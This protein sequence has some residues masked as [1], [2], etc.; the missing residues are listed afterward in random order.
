[1]F[2][3]LLVLAASMG[4]R[5]IG[6]GAGLFAG[7]LVVGASIGVIMVLLPGIIKRDFGARAGTMTGVYT[8]ALCL[9]AALAA[10]L[11]VPLEQL[12]GNSW[13][14]ALAIWLVPALVAAVSWWPHMRHV[15]GQKT[16]RRYRVQGL[17]SSA[18]AWQVTAYLGLQSTLAY[19][20]FGWLPTIL[21]DRGMAPLAAGAMLSL[22]I[23][24]Q[25]I[26]ALGGPWL[27]ARGRD[28]RAA[29]ATMMLLSLAGYAGC[30]YAG[31]D[32]IWLWAVL[33]GLGQ[34]GAFSIGMT[35]IVLRAPNAEVAA[36]LSAMAQGIGYTG[37]ALGPFAF[38]LLRDLSQ[39]WNAAS[40]FFTMVGVA[41]LIAGL[42]AG[43]NR[44]VT[45]TVT[46]VA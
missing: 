1:M 37:A 30:V 9:G 25:L 14:A 10:G 5:V 19:C 44:S 2:H 7:T 34:G 27:A 24:M 31:L 20:V 18:L 11:T 3:G 38:G 4:L 12:S 29:I 21:I 22:S 43:R 35:L 28:Q 26:T 8:M 16:A 6:G 39:D 42:A 36:S 13:R 23:A 45:A 33:L 32:S 17:R 46:A 40:V 41:A 15:H